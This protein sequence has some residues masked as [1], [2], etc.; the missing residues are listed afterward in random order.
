MKL[1]SGPRLVLAGELEEVGTGSDDLEPW[2]NKVG[3][4]G[5][6]VGYGIRHQIWRLARQKVGLK[7]AAHKY[8]ASYF[9]TLEVHVGLGN[10]GLTHG[11]VRSEEITKDCPANNSIL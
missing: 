3:T 1:H 7:Y 8:R 5:V 9:T 11:D 10:D 6:Q 4:T 2:R